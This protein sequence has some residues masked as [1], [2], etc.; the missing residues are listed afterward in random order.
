MWLKIYLQ[1]FFNSFGTWTLLACGQQIVDSGLAG[2]L[3]ATALLFVAAI[4]LGVAL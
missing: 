1:A 2:V 3:N 4:L